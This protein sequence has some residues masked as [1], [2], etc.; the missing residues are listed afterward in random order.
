MRGVPDSESGAPKFR[1]EID[2]G[3][4]S[5]SATTCSASI[6]IIVDDVSPLATLAGV[7]GVVAAVL[8]PG[9]SLGLLL[10]LGLEL[11][12]AYLCRACCV[13]RAWPPL[14]LGPVRPG[15]QRLLGTA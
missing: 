10:L 5:V 12:S 4:L 7:L 3:V 8:D 15:G 6:L 11:S 14:D 2:T 1:R 9:T 13:A